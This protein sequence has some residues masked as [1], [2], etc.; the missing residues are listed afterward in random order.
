MLFQKYPDYGSLRIFGSKCFPCLRDYVKNKL[1]LPSLPCVFLG[2]SDHYKRYRCYHPPSTRVYLSQHVVFDDNSF[3][4]KDP[5]SLYQF[6]YIATDFSN[7]SEWLTDSPTTNM[8]SNTSNMNSDS[9]PR[10]YTAPTEL[11]QNSDSVLPQSS[12]TLGTDEPNEHNFQHATGSSPISSYPPSSPTRTSPST[13]IISMPT[14]E[15]TLYVYQYP[16]VDPHG[17]YLNAVKH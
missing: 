2:Y 6:H 17:A 16:S 15:Q 1:E 4:F 9:D 13:D 11:S 10:L 3:P 12:P 8:N 5:G 7:F 14:A